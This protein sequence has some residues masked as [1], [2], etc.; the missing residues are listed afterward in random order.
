MKKKFFIAVALLSTVMS[1]A[2]QSA[3][4]SGGEASGS[5]GSASF[6]LGQ[7][8]YTTPAGKGG[9][10][11]QGLQQSYKISEVVSK[12]AKGKGTLLL[13]TYPN[14][15]TDGV[16]LDI[17]NFQQENLSY[18]LLSISGQ[19]LKTQKITENTTAIVLKEMAQGT[20]VL[21]VIQENTTVKTFKIIKN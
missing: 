19:V 9:S 14:P 7:V 8:A 10:V 2:Q 21:K 3:V 12:N 16:T 11:A 6:T 4:A 5:K 17:Q 18:A 13:T 20:Y 15:T 1:N